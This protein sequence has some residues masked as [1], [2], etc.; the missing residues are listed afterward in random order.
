MR[1][2]LPPY[3]VHKFSRGHILNT[4]RIIWVLPVIAIILGT[5]INYRT[6]SSISTAL[7]NVSQVDYPFLSSSKALVVDLTGLQE[8]LKT[9]VSTG[10]KQGMAVIEEKGKTFNEELAKLGKI[11]GMEAQ[12]V[13]IRTQFGTYYKAATNATEIMLTIKEGDIAAA[14]PAMQASLQELNKKLQLTNEQATQKF[15]ANIQS[16]RDDSS[17]SLAIN[18]AVS[19]FILVISLGTSSFAIGSVL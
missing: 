18:I 4:K 13:E 10:D 7:T 19:A 16:S 14:V 1:I 6:S 11:P 9:V 5:F 3:P 8:S 2:L 12:A 17:H 15:E